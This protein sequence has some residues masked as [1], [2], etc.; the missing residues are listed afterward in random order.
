MLRPGKQPGVTPALLSFSIDA[1]TFASPRPNQPYTG[2]VVVGSSDSEVKGELKI[3]VSITVANARLEASPSSAGFVYYPCTDTLEA[4]TETVQVVGSKDISFTI[5][6]SVVAAA[7]VDSPDLAAWVTVNPKSGKTG[8]T[9]TLNFDPSK[10]SRNVETTSF[11][12]LGDEKVGATP[13]DRLR[14]VKVIAFCATSR[15]HMPIIGR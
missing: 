14:E 5:L 12:I 8:D 3:P 9:L 1:T 7:G 10:W 13:G 6:T 11:F 4:L 2:F 15:Q